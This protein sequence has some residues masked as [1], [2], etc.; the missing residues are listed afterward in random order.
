MAWI[1]GYATPATITQVLRDAMVAAG[2]TEV[3]NPAAEEYILQTTTDPEGAIRAPKALKAVLTG[4]AA[5]GTGL[6]GGTTYDYAV[7]AEGPRGESV[8]SATVSIT[9]P[10]TPERVK[11]SWRLVDGALRYHIYRKTG[12]GGF[13]RVGSTEGQCTT[14]I[15]DGATPQAGVT[16]PAGQSLTI[17]ARIRRPNASKF[18]IEVSMLE[19]YD[20]VAA[21]ATNESPKVPLYFWNAG[22]TTPSWGDNSQLLYWGDVSKNRI[23]LVI[24]GDPTI[25]FSNYRVGFLYLGRLTPFPESGQDIAGNFALCGNWAGTTTF[26]NQQTYGPNTGGGVLDILVYKTRS[27]VLYQKHELAFVTQRSGMALENKGFNPS[28]W[29]QKYHLSPAYV[30]HGYDGYRGWLEDV[31]VVQDHNL[32]HLDEFIVSYPDGGTERYKYFKV[33]PAGTWPIG[34]A[35]PNANY[36]VA[37]LKEAV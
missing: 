21:T 6:T 14:W 9:Q 26:T 29:T 18:S 11:V 22:A 36:S 8:A 5:T 34:A 10:T 4:A 30:V 28:Q 27:G 17:L 12:T 37:I 25:D 33:N 32:V 16:P 3:A 15:D 35:S 7:T 20:T 24:Y 1:Q 23:A 2:W 31:L 13:E 19:A